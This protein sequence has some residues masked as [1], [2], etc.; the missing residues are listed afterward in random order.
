MPCDNPT[1]HPNHPIPSTA[2][3]A[4]AN[5]PTAANPSSPASMPASPS[6][7]FSATTAA[8]PTSSA[9]D[10]MMATAASMARRPAPIANLLYSSLEWYAARPGTP[11]TPLVVSLWI[12]QAGSLVRQYQDLLCQLVEVQ[13]QTLD[14]HW[15]M[16]S[17]LFAA[18]EEMLGDEPIQEDCTQ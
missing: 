12:R 15:K 10:E 7:P 17:H 5:P 11:P 16:N 14:A 18:A 9:A 13:V 3:P 4:D 1:D 8:A 6:A 2:R